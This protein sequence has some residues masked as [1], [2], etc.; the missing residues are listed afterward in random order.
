MAFGLITYDSASQ[1]SDFSEYGQMK[2]RLKT[3]GGD[4]V[5]VQFIDLET[6][7]C[8][9]EDFGEG[10]DKLYFPIFATHRPQ[11]EDYVDQL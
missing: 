6:K 5:G 3:W 7:P 10:S 11:V 4:T 2:A 8:S 9:L 1:D